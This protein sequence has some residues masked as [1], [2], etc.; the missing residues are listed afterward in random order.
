MCLVTRAEVVTLSRDTK[1]DALVTPFVKG[2]MAAPGT[3]HDTLPQVPQCTPTS[4]LPGF[5]FIKNM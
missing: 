3:Y 4:S 2:E 5:G 1:V